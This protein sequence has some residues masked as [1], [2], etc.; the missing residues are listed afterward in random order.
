MNKID[1]KYS[2]Q[3][4]YKLSKILQ[5]M[6]LNM[7]NKKENDFDNIFKEVSNL[8]LDFIYNTI[9]NGIIHFEDLNIIFKNYGYKEDALSLYQESIKRK[10]NSLI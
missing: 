9:N 4:E 10:I 5:S 7:I 2:L 8:L 3:H 1:L 6:S